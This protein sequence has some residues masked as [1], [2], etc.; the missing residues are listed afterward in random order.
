[1]TQERTTEKLV[2]PL[3]TIYVENHT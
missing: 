3:H 1:M 2:S